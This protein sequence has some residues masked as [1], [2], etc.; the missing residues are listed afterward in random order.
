MNEPE[1][2]FQII[3]KEIKWFMKIFDVINNNND[4]LIRKKYMNEEANKLCLRLHSIVKYLLKKKEI[5][6]LYN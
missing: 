3:Q 1:H 4:E 5:E 2:E 6:I